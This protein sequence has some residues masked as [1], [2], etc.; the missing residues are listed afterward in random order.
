[1]HKIHLLLTP[2]NWLGLGNAAQRRSF[3]EIGR[4]LRHPQMVAIG[5][6]GSPQRC[7]DELQ[8]HSEYVFDDGMTL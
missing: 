8:Q 6:S 3:V 1:M 5:D 2:A 4:A 7:L